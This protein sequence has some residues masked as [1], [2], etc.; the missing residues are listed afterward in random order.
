[1]SG[2]P[3]FGRA[4]IAYRSSYPRPQYG[5]VGR[6]LANNPLRREEDLTRDIDILSEVSILETSLMAAVSAL[7][8]SSMPNS[9]LVGCWRRP[10]SSV[11]ALFS[12]E[13]LMPTGSNLEDK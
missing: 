1:M 7:E 5:G 4:I 11:L 10:D 3:K 9:A 2:S 13:V 8:L 12:F 6:D